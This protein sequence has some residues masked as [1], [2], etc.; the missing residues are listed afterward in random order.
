MP[1]IEEVL[2]AGEWVSPAAREERVVINPSTL[3]PL[4]AVGL[5]EA[6]QWGE[7]LRAAGAAADAWRQRRPEERAALLAGVGERLLAIREELA[8]IHA[9][10][11][12]QVITEALDRVRDAAACWRIDP[13][14]A[15]APAPTVSVVRPRS[16]GALL[17]W[18]QTVAERLARGGT[19]VVALPVETP[20]TVLGAA[21]CCAVLPRGVLS[22]LVGEPILVQDAGVEH[23]RP[24][25]APVATD[26]VYVSPDAD[27]DLAVAGVSAR[28]LYHCGQRAGQSVRVYVERS[29]IYAFA[30]RLH[31]SL[32]FLE[33]GDA[34]K[35]GSDLGPL[36]SAARLQQVEAQ[37]AAVLRRGALIKLG[38]RRYQPWGLTGYF[39]QPTL[40]I[41]G[42]GE[43]RAPEDRIRGPVIVLSPAR[44]LAAA[45]A[46]RPA[47]APVRIS[48]FAGD[49]PR[50]LAGVDVE[51]HRVQIEPVVTR[52]ADWFPYQ[53]RS[54]R[55]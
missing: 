36:A 39:F 38:G 15:S 29:R 49:V 4:G 5:A 40:M 28:R 45:I 54:A 32:A 7:A 11:S 47:A 8:L 27:L 26:I 22:V 48:L 30:D 24:A 14:A 18:S 37:V 10:E 34:V 50:A 42:T 44:D 1:E 51:P 2:I 19:C 43:E 46:D 17:D 3:Q 35:P 41:E 16:D 55:R 13:A 23:V 52:G 33:V 21:R 53:A 9:R 6:S 12:G 20:L 25:D 31:E